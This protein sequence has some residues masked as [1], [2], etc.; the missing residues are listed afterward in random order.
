M[1]KKLKSSSL[2]ATWA[3]SYALIMTIFFFAAVRMFS[4][5]NSGL[6]D[7][8][9]EFNNYVADNIS[10]SASNILSSE[11]KLQYIVHSH[12]GFDALLDANNSDEYFS[13][14]DIYEYIKF[15]SYYGT[16]LN[17]IDFFY[18]YIPNTDA[19][20]SVSGIVNSYDFYNTY[21]SECGLSYESWKNHL[22]NNNKYYS[23]RITN[24]DTTFDALGYNVKI[25]RNSF[26]GSKRYAILVTVINSQQF[27]VGADKIKW[28]KQSDIFIYDDA[29]NLIL[30]KLA[31]NKS[32]IPSNIA[33]VK[34]ISRRHN[35]TKSNISCDLT[36]MSV[37]TVTPKDIMYKKSQYVRRT[38]L[39]TIF[40]CFVLVALVAW[41][42]IYS[43][44]KN[45][46]NLLTLLSVT[47]K[48]DEY[49]A[50]QNAIQ[51]II[52]KNNAME[53]IFFRQN[54]E[55]RRMELSVMLKH[56]YLTEPP[57]ENLKRYG[58]NFTH[59]KFS[60]VT[61]YVDSLEQSLRDFGEIDINEKYKNICFIISNIFEELLNT[62]DKTAYVTDS[63]NIIACILNYS[64]DIEDIIKILDYGIDFINSSFD[65]I[66][67]YS[68][69]GEHT[70]SGDISA[71]YSETLS[72][73]DYKHIFDIY[74]SIKYDDTKNKHENYY[75]FTLEK[76]QL[77]IS[78]LKSGDF[79][80]VKE[81]LTE[82]FGK[83]LGNKNIS[84]EYMR[85]LIFDI[86]SSVFKLPDSLDTNK[87]YLTDFFKNNSLSLNN[88]SFNEM[89][90]AILDFMEH[91][92]EYIR[93]LDLSESKMIAQITEFLEEN[94]ADPNLNTASVGNA[95]N[96]SASYIS[97]KFKK[98][99]GET[100]ASYI[101][102]FRIE[103]S[104]ELIRNTNYP[105][106]SIA[107]MVGFS[108]IRTFNR[109]FKK[110][111]GITPSEFRS[112]LG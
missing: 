17:N 19:V 103:K 3:L 22:N 83:V 72:A 106:N 63:D 35:V 14:K 31:S 9:N 108:H 94:Y 4:S 24:N 91:L 88:K 49:A 64:C 81:F 55:L 50:L 13:D 112:K 62:K 45:V 57:T 32:F 52:T 100:L 60:V 67:N 101:T 12:N 47:S 77:L 21:M 85:C 89:T 18:L 20:I 82:I 53:D 36:E 102:I 71:A 30:S 42:F 5:F 59:K 8:I 110:Y 28:T 84:A 54:D 10:R 33:Q 46:N 73:I 66:I 98:E 79:D 78:Y 41:L 56:K 65:L 15:L 2:I 99:S 44:Y 25:T 109:V 23:T 104:K 93:T 74:G 29:G 111:E 75:F 97:K 68:L 80:M 69:S 107:E 61:F 7:E 96:I 16:H 1:N 27:F 86:A 90:A 48:K 6:K 38:A 58:I 43:N 51:N 87:E 70:S 92:C 95:F 11:K 105:L 26:S 76:E 40:I 37:V 39:L 34:N